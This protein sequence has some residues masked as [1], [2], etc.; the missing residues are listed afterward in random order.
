LLAG[1]SNSA[2][3]YVAFFWYFSWRSK[4]STYAL[5]FE[6]KKGIYFFQLNPKEKYT[7]K[8]SG[9]FFIPYFVIFSRIFPYIWGFDSI[10]LL[11]LL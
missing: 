3:P 11:D 6:S 10:F 5:L 4:K 8:G 2:P 1:A 7:E 9:V